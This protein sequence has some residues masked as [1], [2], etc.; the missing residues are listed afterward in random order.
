[1]GY[2]P[3]EHVVWWTFTNLTQSLLV[4]FY[5]VWQI[6]LA[7]FSFA[8]VNLAVEV[9]LRCCEIYEKLQKGKGR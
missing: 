1:M 4:K 6:F 9:D 3:L 2:P 8:R 5:Q 7:K